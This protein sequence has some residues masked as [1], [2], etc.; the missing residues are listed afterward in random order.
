MPVPEFLKGSPTVYE[1]AEQ[2]WDLK[3]IPTQY[4]FSLLTQ[5]SE[6]EL[7]KEKC[8]ELSS[9]EGQEEWL[10]YC[11]RPRRTILEVLRD[12][13]KSTSKLTLQIIFELFSPIRPRSFSISSSCLA[14]HGQSVD[15][16]VAV[17]EYHTKLKKPRLG[18]A[19]NWLKT[20]K[21]GDKIYGWFKNGTFVF[22]DDKNIPCIM[23]GPG[24][25]VAPFRS[26]ILEREYE[27]T[28]KKDVLLLYFGCR[29]EKKDFH[30]REDFERLVKENK[31]TLVCAFSRD[32]DN[33]VYVQHKIADNRDYLW[34]L[35][36]E[37]KA[38]IF[39]SGNAKNMPDNVKDA[40]MEEVFHKSGGLS[41]EDAKELIKSMETNEQ[42]QIETW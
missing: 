15:L 35:I 31:L 26:Y 4:V 11:R 8:I 9:P 20:L 14:S 42:L 39:I 40:F 19:S 6:D 34:P 18:L 33:K 29:Y 16:L 28:A 21:E 5:V 3:F 13:H 30:C 12:F 10:N 36:K 23:I 22:P 24:A 25:G 2:Y 7:E 38:M 1:I 17:L 32:E 37:R 41:L 27:N